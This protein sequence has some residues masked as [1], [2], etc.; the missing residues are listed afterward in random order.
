MF[1]E[2][3]APFLGLVFLIAFTVD[4]T[5]SVI[6]DHLESKELEKECRTQRRIEKMA[7]K[8]MW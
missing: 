7:K 1:V 8:V 6:S 4:V 5:L 2:A 3:F